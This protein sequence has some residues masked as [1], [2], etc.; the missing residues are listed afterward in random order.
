MGNLWEAFKF[1]FLELNLNWFISYGIIVDLIF[2]QMLKT[3]YF[4]SKVLFVMWFVKLN[5]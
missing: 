5:Y 2:P 1:L 3:C 4:A